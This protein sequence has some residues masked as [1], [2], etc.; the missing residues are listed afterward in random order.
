[1]KDV[2]L[3]NPKTVAFI[4]LIRIYRKYFGEARIRGSHHIFKTP[5]SGD[6]RINLQKDGKMAKSYQVKE[7]KKAIEKLKDSINMKESSHG[8]GT[9]GGTAARSEKGGS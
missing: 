4:D 7:V 5:W 6:T 1:M 2:D 9:G 3:D 8:K